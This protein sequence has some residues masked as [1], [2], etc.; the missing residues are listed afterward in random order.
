MSVSLPVRPPFTVFGGV[1]GSPSK[2]TT[3]T[4]KYFSGLFGI[5]MTITL[6]ASSDTI[7]RCSSST[8]RWRHNPKHQKSALLR[9]PSTFPS[10][11]RAP[12]HFLIYAKSSKQPIITDERLCLWWSWWED[13][14]LIIGSQVPTSQPASQSVLRI[15]IISSKAFKY[16][17]P[18]RR[19]RSSSKMWCRRV[20][21]A[22]LVLHLHQIR[23]LL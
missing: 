7:R 12:N 10:R 8:R 14:I 11:T 23:P 13:A 1:D 21:K 5:T 17:L 15:P 22:R 4:N 3:W 9:P 19:V 16:E 2:L 18:S 20:G 6:A